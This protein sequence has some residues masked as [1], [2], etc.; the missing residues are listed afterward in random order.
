VVAKPF[1][2]RGG[3]QFA[4]ARL[5]PRQTMILFV[6]LRETT[7]RSGAVCLGRRSDQVHSF[8]SVPD[9]EFGG[10]TAQALTTCGQWAL[11]VGARG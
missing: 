6:F 9:A 10:K 7:F 8:Q 4:G 5:A 2:D 11:P 1:C 3:E